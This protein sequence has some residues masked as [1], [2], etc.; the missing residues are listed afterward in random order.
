MRSSL[1]QSIVVWSLLLC[2]MASGCKG[3]RVFVRNTGEAEIP[4]YVPEIP[5]AQKNRKRMLERLPGS[6]SQQDKGGADFEPP[7]GLAEQ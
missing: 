6:G 2:V 4:A 5:T 3:R 7:A 1:S